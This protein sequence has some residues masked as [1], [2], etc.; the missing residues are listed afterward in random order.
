MSLKALSVTPAGARLVALAD[1][2]GYWR[3]L[4]FVATHAQLRVGYG[5]GAVFMRHG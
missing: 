2:L 4:G 5:A 1:A 3:R